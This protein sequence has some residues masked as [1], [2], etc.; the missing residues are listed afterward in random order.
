MQADSLRLTRNGLTASGLG[1]SPFL[2]TSFIRGREKAASREPQAEGEHRL[3]I[4]GRF[5]AGLRLRLGLRRLQQECWRTCPAR[6][7]E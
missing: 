6:A 2:R 4:G 1:R 5:A 7:F 3:T